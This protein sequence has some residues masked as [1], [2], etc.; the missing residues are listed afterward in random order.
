MRRS[1]SL[2]W[3]L[4]SAL[5]LGSAAGMGLRSKAAVEVDPQTG[6]ATDAAA[7]EP[8]IVEGQFLKLDG[9]NP[10]KYTM[11]DD[12]KLVFGKVGRWLCGWGEVGCGCVGVGGGEE[13][14]RT[15]S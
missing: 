15:K 14:Y 5:L 9:F 3:L 4:A 1:Q 12:S 10:D 13:V 2:R 7:A 11:I 8:H 6:E